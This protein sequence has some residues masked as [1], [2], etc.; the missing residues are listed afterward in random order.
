[1]LPIDFLYM[2]VRGLKLN[3]LCRRD[4]QLALSQLPAYAGGSESAV[5]QR[6]GKD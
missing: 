4:R 2:P 5:H 6:G 3:Y 1:L